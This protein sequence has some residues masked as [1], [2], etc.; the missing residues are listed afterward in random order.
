M[1]FEFKPSGWWRALW[2]MVF[3]GMAAGAF[4]QAA[5]A[6]SREFPPGTLNRIEDLPAGRFRTQIDKLPL[7]GRQR[8]LEW[9]QRFHFTELDLDSLHADAEGGIFYVDH[10]TLAPQ[11]PVDST[12]IT[13]L[14][15]VPVSP[16]PA[17]LVFHSRPGAPNTL[18][19]NFSGE[20]VSGTLWNT[21]LGRS[22]IPAQAFSTDADFANFSD[23]EQLAVKRIWQR[24][25]EDY[26]PF[27]IDVTTERPAT[28]TTRAAGRCCFSS[29]S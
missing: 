27:D 5:P 13:G 3:V 12:P 6:R 10:F 18:F 29:R 9:L 4:G 14:A 7:A 22:V 2:V 19:I 25:A 15:S 23:S 28:L 17:S 24:V 26:A 20:S 8:A 16:F 21:S 1:D 11:A